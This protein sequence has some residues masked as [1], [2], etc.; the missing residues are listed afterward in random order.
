METKNNT[1]R[2]R[3][4]QSEDRLGT[5]DR[6]WPGQ[7]GMHKRSTDRRAEGNH[8]PT[9]AITC[10]LEQSHANWGNHMLTGAITCQLEQS[11]ANWGNHMLTG[12][13]TCQLEQSHPNWS[14][15]MPTGAITCQ[16]GQ[17]H[18]N[19]GNHMLTG[20]SIVPLIEEEN[21]LL[22]RQKKLLVFET[23]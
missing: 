7:G 17:S 9:G 14:N 22:S 15:H 2:Q 3:N 11:H 12:A 20:A 8:M 10:Q 5:G 1:Y 6:H 4:M 18:A 19:W 21:P 23:L 13:I 16:L